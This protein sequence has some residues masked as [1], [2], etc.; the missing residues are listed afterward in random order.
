LLETI[1]DRCLDYRNANETISSVVVSSVVE[2]LAEKLGTL[3]PKV[4]ELCAE[5]VLVLLPKVTPVKGTYAH[6]DPLVDQTT[7]R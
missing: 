5:I 4:M 6:S 1:L 3:P 7:H 2:A